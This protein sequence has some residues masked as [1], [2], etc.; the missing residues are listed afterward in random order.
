MVYL[1]VGAFQSH[2]PHIINQKHSYKIDLGA[3]T[4]TTKEDIFVP[5]RAVT[6]TEQRQRQR[7]KSEQSP[8]IPRACMGHHDNSQT[9]HQWEGES[10]WG[11]HVYPRLIHV[12]V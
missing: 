6:M 7:Q 10:G 2:L 1:P 3:S 5:D 4:P 8:S 11:I 12:N 9:L